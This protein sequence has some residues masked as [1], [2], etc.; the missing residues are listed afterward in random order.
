MAISAKSSPFRR[1]NRKSR[2]RGFAWLIV[3]M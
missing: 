3:V 1:F 2:A